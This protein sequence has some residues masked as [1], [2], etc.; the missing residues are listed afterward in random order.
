MVKLHF[1]AEASATS[2]LVFSGR[3]LKICTAARRVASMPIHF[4]RPLN[5]AIIQIAIP[6]INPRISNKIRASP[7]VCTMN[8]HIS[9]RAVAIMGKAKNCFSVSIQAPGLGRALI[10][11]GFKASNKYGPAKPKPSARKI[12][13]VAK[14]GCKSA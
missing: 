1:S 4:H 8:T 5:V 12:G 10:H 11:S 9:Q 3:L 2:P 6:R 14:E 13:K 7:E